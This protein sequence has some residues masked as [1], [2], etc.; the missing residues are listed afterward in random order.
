MPV[1]SERIDHRPLIRSLPFRNV[2]VQKIWIE[3]DV[4]YQYDTLRP[5]LLRLRSALEQ[6][7]GEE[8]EGRP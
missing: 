6:E 4:L 2:L 1:S 5:L 3:E 7:V 8:T